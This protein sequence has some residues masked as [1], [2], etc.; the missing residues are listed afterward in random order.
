MMLTSAII[1]FGIHSLTLHSLGQIESSSFELELSVSEWFFSTFCC[2]KS[3]DLFF[4]LDWFDTTAT[5]SWSLVDLMVPICTNLSCSWIKDS[6][7]SSSGGILWFQTFSLLEWNVKTNTKYSIT[8]FK[9][10]DKINYS[11]FF[12]MPHCF[13]WSTND[14]NFV[15]KSWI[16]SWYDVVSI[17]VRNKDVRWIF[18]I[19]YQDINIIIT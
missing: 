1:T 16:S 4:P 19:E 15:K 6:M 13:S 10:I 3:L 9:M 14:F 18:Y 17:I 7:K 12:S 8:I 2:F 5:R 11:C